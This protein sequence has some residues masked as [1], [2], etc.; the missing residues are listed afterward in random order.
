M[1]RRFRV[2]LTAGRRSSR[3][4]HYTSPAGGAVFTF[5]CC[6]ATFICP[7][8]W[9]MT[10]LLCRRMSHRARRVRRKIRLY[11]SIMAA[12]WSRASASLCR[13]GPHL[14]SSLMPPVVGA[15]LQVGADGQGLQPRQVARLRL[16]HGVDELPLDAVPRPPVG[17]QFLPQRQELRPL[18]GAVVDRLD[19]LGRPVAGPEFVQ[20]GPFDLL[21]AGGG[22]VGVGAGDRVQVEPTDLIGRPGQRPL[23]AVRPAVRRRVGR[24]PPATG[25][26][27]SRRAAPSGRT[28]WPV[29][30]PARRPRSV[31]RAWLLP[32]SFRHLTHD[33]HQLPPPHVVAPAHPICDVIAGSIRF[34]QTAPAS[35][36]PVR[37][38][39]AVYGGAGVRPGAQIWHLGR[40]CLRSAIPASVTRVPV[41]RTPVSP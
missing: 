25:R 2:R 17:R 26:S 10:G 39:T 5:T 24:P 8:F 3:F 14:A 23:A 19:G 15:A 20:G 35:H 41:S 30:R 34:R 11:R 12:A 37:R 36:N 1:E 27:A 9:T 38:G 28:T 29:P 7:P 22:A 31:P 6:W 33:G 21:P 18:P 16:R 13:G 4:G 32:R 40:A